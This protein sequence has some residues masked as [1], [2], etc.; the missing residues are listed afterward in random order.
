MELDLAEL[1]ADLRLQKRNV[2]LAIGALE[3][4]ARR[5][6]GPQLACCGSRRGRV[7]MDAQ[8]RQKVSER[9]RRYWASRRQR[10]A[11]ETQSALA[12]TNETSSARAVA[13]IDF[14][15]S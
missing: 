2:E 1:I 3:Q 10:T 13:A 12:R 9:M 14:I 11:S 4:L 8:E 5:N 15:A 6:A 7:F